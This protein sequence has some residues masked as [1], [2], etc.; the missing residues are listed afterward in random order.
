M[1]PIRELPLVA[2]ILLVGLALFFGGGPGDGSIPWLGGGALLAIL[3]CLAL[4]GVPRGW[5]AVVPLVALAAW[6][7][8]SIDWSWLPDR[9]WD[10]ANRTLVYALF[11][12]LGLFVAGR[13]RALANGLAAVLAAVIGWSLLGKVLPPVYDYGSPFVSARLQGPI[14]LWNQLALAADFALVLALWRRG[15]SGTLLAYLA[16]VALFLTYSRGGIL[17]AVV[18][19]GAWL[20]FGGAW[21]DSVATLL[22]AAL[23]AG[24]AVGIAFALP[25]VTGT[26]QAS[27]V[28]WRDGLVFGAVLLVG[29]AASLALERVRRP[30]DTAAL[31]RGALAVAGLGLAA[32]IAVL[33][34]HGIGS[35]TVSNNGGRVFST[36]SN[37]RFT[38]WH[39]AWRGFEHHA[40]LGTGAGSFNLVNALYR[41]TF[42]DETT[43]PHN[44]PLQFLQETGLVGFVLLVLALA[45]LLRPGW[46]RSGHELALAL[47]LPAFVVH[48]LVD[49]DWDFLAVAAPAFLAAGAIAGR[50]AESRVSAFAFFPAVGI[51]VLAFVVLL[52]PWLGKRWA[53]DAYFRSITTARGV[54]ALA[55]RAHSV[56]PLLLE[57]YWAHAQAAYLR[58]EN[59]L[60]FAWYVQAVKRQPHN[61][62]TWNTAGEYAFNLQCYGRAYDY[63]E[64][65]T[66]LNQKAQPSAGGDDYNAAL[67]KVNL[68]EYSC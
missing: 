56:D 34:V 64:K 11:A 7:A 39:Q 46:R 48:S 57:P 10:Y 5:P 27:H 21:L 63:L 8:V 30:R 59:S 38:W 65:F 52:L 1:R 66:E 20:L 18:V 26:A 37:F 58:G 60:A 54:D 6:C 62:R 24:A 17:T 47:L 19:G 41:S 51:A 53:D 28:R 45:A 4:Y 55:N 16:L 44:L 2:S 13:T 42:L 43:E 22:A 14:G 67:K 31:R 68:G 23:P 33:V 50:P 25:G 15:R 61:W 36:S 9:S 12:T 35:G 29:A 49:V 32:G 40:L 3:A